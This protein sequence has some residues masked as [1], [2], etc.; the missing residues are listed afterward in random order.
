MSDWIPR[1]LGDVFEI[2]LGKMLSP[3]AK[4]GVGNAPYLRNAN[5]Q[6]GRFDLTHIATMDFDPRE[7]AKFELRPR[8]LLVCESGEP[9][10]C[11]VWE[12]QMADCYYQKALHRLRPKGDAVD[13]YFGMYR[14]MLASGTGEFS[15]SVTH[16]TIAHLP[17]EKLAQ[18]VFPLPRLD[19]QRRIVAKLR[20]KFADLD[21]ARQALADQLDAA[22]KLSAATLREAFCGAAYKLWPERRLGDVLLFR[23]EIVHPRDRPTGRTIFVGMEH[24]ESHTGQRIGSVPIDLAKLTG[25][26][27]RFYSG[28]LVYGY[29]RPYLNKLWLADRE[30]CCSVDQY[31][32][33]VRR[34]LGET[35][36]VAHFMR[37]DA[38]LKTAPVELTPGQLPRIRTDEMAAVPIRLPDLGTQRVIAREL[39]Q[40]LKSAR[41][42]CA[43]LSEQLAALD[44]YPAALLRDAFSGR[45]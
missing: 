44:R 4:T 20:E 2:Q 12:G 5:V 28:D 22:K 32:F 33:T 19:E 1:R 24:I 45:I 17:A 10:R 11:A 37:S 16:S 42:L 9:G 3:T 7:R 41:T 6:W 39:N 14:M 31:V 35:D 15:G 29:L 43:S 30:G 36:F 38:Y 27:A 21:R 8:D 13:S 25:R 40:K 34:S 26:K 23:N 18:L